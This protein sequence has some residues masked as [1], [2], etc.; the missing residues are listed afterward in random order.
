M[1][2]GGKRRGALFGTLRGERLTDRNV[3]R[4]LD[5]AAETAKVD[6]VSFHTFRRTCAS[7]LFDGGKNVAQVAKWLG[8]GDPAFTLRTY[9]HL[10]DEG[11]G[12]A[13]FLDGEVGNGWAIQHPA[14]AENQSPA[15]V[16][17]TAA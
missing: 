17:E 2:D 3:R 4:V 14:E 15:E 6:G 11:V 16:A 1:A 8:H 10:L 5:A 12:D 7:I 13:A 9:V